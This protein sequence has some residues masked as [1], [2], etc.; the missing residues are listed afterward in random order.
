MMTYI[1]GGIPL[2][3]GGGGSRGSEVFAAS[4]QAILGFGLAFVGAL[5]LIPS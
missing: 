5:L 4:L 3:S 1:I 2:F